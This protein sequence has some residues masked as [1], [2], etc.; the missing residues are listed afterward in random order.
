[1]FFVGTMN[2]EK[3]I[4]ILRANPKIEISKGLNI[5]ETEERKALPSSDIESLP[6]PEKMEEVAATTNEGGA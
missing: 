2:P 1:M 3:V 4:S 5:F 6:S